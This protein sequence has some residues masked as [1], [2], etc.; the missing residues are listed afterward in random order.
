[1][2]KH[3][4]RQL[5]VQLWG[6]NGV[7]FSI[8]MQRVLSKQCVFWWSLCTTLCL[9]IRYQVGCSRWR[10]LPRALSRGKEWRMNFLKE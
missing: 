3:G 10:V 7:V 1:M 2:A 8:N 6:G 4:K 9:V 5:K